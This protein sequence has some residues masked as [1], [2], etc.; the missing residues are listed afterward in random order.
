MTEIFV[1]LA[2]T[3][4]SVQIVR[5]RLPLAIMARIRGLFG[6]P[7]DDLSLRNEVAH[8]INSIYYVALVVA[9][10]ACYIMDYP[11]W[12]AIAYAAITGLIEE[13]L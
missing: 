3:Y 6:T 8:F 5:G 4:I 12:R 11:Y 7:N 2:I 10:V 1:S 9:L 13:K